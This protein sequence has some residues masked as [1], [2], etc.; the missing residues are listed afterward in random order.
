MIE[1]PA[2]LDR[3]AAQAFGHRLGGDGVYQ[4]PRGRPQEGQVVFRRWFATW[5]NGEGIGRAHDR[6]SIDTPSE[7]LIT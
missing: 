5:V 3:Q 1:R 2:E 4:A 6:Y 7:N